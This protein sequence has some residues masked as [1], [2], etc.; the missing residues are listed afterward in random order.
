VPF[1]KAIHQFIAIMGAAKLTPLDKLYKLQFLTVQENFT[2]H[3]DFIRKF[4]HVTRDEKWP[5]LTYIMI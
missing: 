3:K 4:G 1:K 2:Q 5:I